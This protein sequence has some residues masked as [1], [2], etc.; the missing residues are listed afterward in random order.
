MPGEHDSIQAMSAATGG[1]LELANSIRAELRQDGVS[2]HA[3]EQ[4]MAKVVGIAQKAYTMGAKDGGNG[5]GGNGRA[6]IEPMPVMSMEPARP[7]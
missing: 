3:V 6:T 2:S 7:G 5:N 4:V 1:W